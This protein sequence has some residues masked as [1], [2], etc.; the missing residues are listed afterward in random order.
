[1]KTSEEFAQESSQHEDTSILPSK[2]EKKPV[3]IIVTMLFAA[4]ILMT[5]GFGF[6]RLLFSIRTLSD[7]SLMFHLTGFLTGQLIAMVFTAA[8]LVACIRRPVWG[9]IVSMVFAVAFGILCIATLL[10][11]NPDP[12]FKIAPGAEEEGAYMA[13]A[14]LCLGVVAYVWS[15]TF[16]ARTKAYFAEARTDSTRQ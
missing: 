8:V 1:M 16:G 13:R 10:S 11:P 15:M 9:R 6:I 4:L 12:V 2:K 14:L 5:D 7:R 3:A